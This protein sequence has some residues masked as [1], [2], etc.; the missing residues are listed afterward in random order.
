MMDGALYVGDPAYV[1]EKIQHLKKALGTVHRFAM[2]TPVG[3]LDHE[4]VRAS[5]QLFGEKV[6]PYV[7]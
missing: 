6:A 1:I 4:Q 5:I 3:F 7:R 2:H